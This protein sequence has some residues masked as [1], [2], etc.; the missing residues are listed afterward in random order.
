MFVEAEMARIAASAP[1]DFDR[2]PCKIDYRCGLRRTRAGID[3]EV[4]LAFEHLS[5]R[6]GIVQRL[7][8]VRKDQRGRE[9]RL[10]QFFE[11]R[12]DHRVVGYADTD[13][14]ALRMLQPSR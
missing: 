12:L 1:H 2:L 3:N 13:G 11:Q 7:C 6:A 9:N 8:C 5:Y 4:E 10:A 14:A